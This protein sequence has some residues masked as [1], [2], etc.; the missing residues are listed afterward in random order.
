MTDSAFPTTPEELTVAW[1][2]DVLRGAGS[3]DGAVASVCVDR[4]GIVSGFYGDIARLHL[5]YEGASGMGPATMVAKFPT[6]EVAARTIGV[7]RGYYEREVAFYEQL[8]SACGLRVPACYGAAVHDEATT[9]LLLE[10][11]SA[12]REAT[13]EATTHA[14][15]ASV[16]RQLAVF[17]ARSWDVDAVGAYPWLPST[18]A[19]AERFQREFPIA[20]PTICQW[21]QAPADADV[22]RAGDWV[23]EHVPAVKGALGARPWAFLHADLRAQNL[24]FDADGSGTAIVVDWQHCRRGRAAFDVATYLFGAASSLSEDDERALIAE[25]HAALTEA[26]VSGYSMEE[27]RRDY[28]L[29]MVDRFVNVGS[30]LA[31]VDAGSEGGRKAVD[32][33][34]ECGMAAFLRH[35]HILETL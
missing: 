3:I 34:R 31:T 26:G 4:G 13:V 6:L 17:H 9:V 30:T 12:H 15:M 22:A 20:W 28:A 5:E 7:Q 24:F 33:L 27:C 35:A 19:G 10:D 2:T 32:Y 16:M 29:A 25:Y 18:D 14:E 23:G 21:V 11:L 8:A 1:L